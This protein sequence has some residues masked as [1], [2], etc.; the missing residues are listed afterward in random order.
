MAHHRYPPRENPPRRLFAVRFS[1]DERN[2]LARIAEARGT[3]MSGVLRQ[4]IGETPT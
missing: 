4:L 3:S 1:E 2:R